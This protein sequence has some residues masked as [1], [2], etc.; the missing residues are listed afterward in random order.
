MLKARALSATIWS[1][2]DILLRQG[3]Q[4]GVS[5]VLARLLA[6]E[7]FGVF[8]ISMVF[9]SLCGVFIDSGFAAALI[10]KQDATAED[11]STVFWFNLGA[12]VIAAAALIISAP[13]LARFFH[14]PGLA[15]LLAVMAVSIFV[16]AVSSI[17]ATLLSKHLDF[18]T[19]MNASVASAVASGLVAIVLASAGYGVWA[20][21]GQ[22]VASAVITTVMLWAL[23]PW[24][25]QLVFSVRSLRSLF[26]F[27]GYMM[28]SILLET[29]ENRASS[30]VIGRFY[31]ARELGFYARADSVSQLPASLIRRIASR[32]SLPVFS[33]AVGD[34]ERLRSGMRQ[35]LVGLMFICA[36][37]MIG[38]A[39]VA[40]SLVPSLFGERWAPST[41]I[42]QVLSLAGLALPFHVVNLS[43]V[44]ALGQSGVFFR[45]HLAKKLVG[46][47]LLAA[48]APLGPLMIAWAVVGSNLVGLI[49]DIV[50][51]GRMV[52]YPALRQL[53]DL[54]PVTGSAILMGAG[55]LAL[56]P[57]LAQNSWV[58]LAEAT[59]LGTL[60]YAVLCWMFRVA[61]LMQA[62]ALVFARLQSRSARSGSPD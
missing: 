7:A 12:A 23:H 3:L 57:L 50:V 15:A 28:L 8:A 44:M 49:I 25:P 14:L 33:H 35:G 36:P 1:G 43:V 27:G 4:F 22:Y 16:S 48:A 31:S 18:K 45:L 34:P 59:A 30:M 46:I 42:L 41:P 54:L 6:P 24:R 29:I 21:A 38:V 32:V 58:R 37:A 13:W 26:A 20:L 47:A 19:Q 17:H 11:E 56:S 5:V 55:V 51:P 2:I 9:T 40:D 10:Q 52:N 60:L 61:P 53:R 62:A 39:V